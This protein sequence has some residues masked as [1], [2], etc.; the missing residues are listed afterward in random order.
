MLL[1]C[2]V[3]HTGVMILPSPWIGAAETMRYGMAAK[4][5]ET[6]KYIILSKSKVEDDCKKDLAR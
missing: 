4:M 6:L 3:I 2:L 5:N 1:N